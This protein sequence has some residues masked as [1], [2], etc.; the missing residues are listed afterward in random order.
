MRCFFKILDKVFDRVLFYALNVHSFV[1]SL[2]RS[3]V[4]L[5]VC[6]LVLTFLIKFLIKHFFMLLIGY[7]NKASF[8]KFVISFSLLKPV[9]WSSFLSSLGHYCS[10]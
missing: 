1:R 2:V 4:C 9:L 5:F 3:L 6:L 8:L 10:V 7:L